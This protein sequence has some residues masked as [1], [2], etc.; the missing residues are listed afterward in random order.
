MNLTCLCCGKDFDSVSSFDFCESCFKEI[1][2]ECAPVFF[3]PI[4]HDIE[5]YDKELRLQ[6]SDFN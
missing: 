3:S 1:H 4:Y 6:V 5:E 2:R